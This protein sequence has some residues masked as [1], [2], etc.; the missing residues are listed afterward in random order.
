MR[1]IPRPRN[2][3]FWPRAAGVLEIVED[4]RG[5]TYRA[6]YMVR[7]AGRVFVLHVFQNKSKHG[8]ATSKADIGLIR[9]RLQ[10]AEQR[11]KEFKP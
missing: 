2:P 7:F 3:F 5:Q 1:F 9:A 10:A 11:A 6:V 8:K 4:W